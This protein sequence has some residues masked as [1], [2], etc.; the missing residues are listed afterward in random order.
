MFLS[1]TSIV[2]YQKSRFLTISIPLSISKFIL[3]VSLSPGDGPGLGRL[4]SSSRLKRSKSS[5][6][7]D[8]DGIE[9]SK[10]ELLS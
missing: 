8:C 7:D 3:S 10:F 4:I 6:S 1:S 2:F 9:G 5:M